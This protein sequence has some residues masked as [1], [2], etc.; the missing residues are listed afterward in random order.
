MEVV[1]GFRMFLVKKLPIASQIATVLSFECWAMPNT[2]TFFQGFCDLLFPWKGTIRCCLPFYAIPQCIS[3]CG[4]QALSGPQG[5]SFTAEMQNHLQ[6]NPVAVLP[7]P[8]SASPFSPT[9]MR[10]GETELPLSGSTAERRKS[11]LSSSF[12][13]QLVSIGHNAALDEIWNWFPSLLSTLEQI[14]A[15][16]NSQFVASKGCD[17]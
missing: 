7:I 6:S 8:C 12:S 11:F 15:R 3:N 5:H 13:M 10:Q 1:V 16:Y 4:L 14:R 17:S 2:E 9:C